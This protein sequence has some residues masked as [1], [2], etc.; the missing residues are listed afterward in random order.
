MLDLLEPFNSFGYYHPEF[1]GS[2][3]LKSVLPA[4]FP[5]EKYSNLNYNQLEIRNGNMAMDSYKF[6]RYEKDMINCLH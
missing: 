6:L 3:S 5:S 2:F 4:I 1:Y